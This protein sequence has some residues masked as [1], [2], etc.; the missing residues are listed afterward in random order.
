MQRTLPIALG[1]VFAIA[2][3]LAVTTAGFT[4]LRVASSEIPAPPGLTDRSGRTAETQELRPAD[5]R[6]AVDVAP[7]ARVAGIDSL[8][9]RSRVIFE[10]LPDAPHELEVSFAF[11]DRAR[12]ALRNVGG[13][14]GARVLRYRRGAQLFGI[15]ADAAT[16][17]PI[18]GEPR[19]DELL[20]LA[21]R[22]ALLVWP[23]SHTWQRE[24]D[25]YLAEVA[26][27]GKLEL[28]TGPFHVAR[29]GSAPA[30]PH[31]T[32]TP[33]SAPESPP[34]LVERPSRV[35]M[36]RRDGSE[37]EVLEVMGWRDDPAARRI[38]PTELTL[39]A[40]G[41]VVWRETLELVDRSVLWAD[42]WFVPP[43]RRQRATTP[44]TPVQSVDLLAETVLDVPFADRPTLDLD[45]ALRRAREVRAALCTEGHEVAEETTLVLASD[46]TPRAVRVVLES[47]GGSPPGWR[48]LPPRPAWVALLDTT[49]EVALP[50]ARDLVAVAGEGRAA[51]AELLLVVTGEARGGVRLVLAASL[52]AR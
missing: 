10:A 13:D 42:D 18:E 38:W 21:G 51:N 15:Q 2:L 9:A 47:R 19:A 44:V 39:H 8:F 17:Q 37:V 4:A 5:D 25:V 46:L 43:D 11:P 31:G 3:G 6:R 36:L 52:S 26:G 30:P 1:A 41:A 33:T 12:A 7:R 34:A 48:A 50:C 22:L 20:G 23:E 45:A 27:L 35:R 49:A 28:R 40:N 16:S 24:G 32:E 29:V 14:R